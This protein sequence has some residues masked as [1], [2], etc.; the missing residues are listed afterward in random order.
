[1]KILVFPQNDQNPYQG[2][3]Y[4]EMERLGDR[5]SYLGRLT[6]S[7]T[8]NLLLLPLETAVRG[9]T[10]ERLVHLH[11]VYGFGLPGAGHLP[12]MR[13]L[14]QAWFRFWLWTIRKMGVP[15]VWTAHNTV[16]H[17]PVFAD[18]VAARRILVTHSDLVIAHS[19]PAVAGLAVLGAPPLR[20]TVIPHGPLAPVVDQVL[21]VCQARMALLFT[22]CSSGKSWNI[23][24][25]KTSFTAFTAL[26]A[27][28]SVRLTVTGQCD[29]A[30]MR[31]R[32]W[33]LARRDGDRI[34]MRLERIPAYDVAPLFMCA[35]VVVLPY[36]RVTTSGS[37]MLGL[38]YGRPLILPSLAAFAQFPHEVASLRRYYRWTYIRHNSSRGHCSPSTGEHGR[39]RSA[40]CRLAVV[41]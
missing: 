8:L 27:D 38:A 7:R 25:L 37:A 5:V 21:G 31:S 13:L 12:A 1:M 30:A 40:F 16:P 11:W 19:E 3:L 17:E 39:R 6:P 36:R 26:P 32:L 22:S 10:R 41:A 18:D 23:K 34:K 28:L 2:L 33:D 9:A 24:A 4:G 35:D 15:L 14:A 29:D 20:S